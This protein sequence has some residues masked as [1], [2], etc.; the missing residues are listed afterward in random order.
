MAQI[1]DIDNDDTIEKA[2][3]DAIIDKES[4]CFIIPVFFIS[5][6]RTSLIKSLGIVITIDFILIIISG[7]GNQVMCC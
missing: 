6:K 2:D 1:V 7:E 4:P 3:I 5:T